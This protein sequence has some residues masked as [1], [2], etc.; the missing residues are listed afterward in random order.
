MN[1]L[2]ANLLFQRQV[3][4]VYIYILKN[5]VFVPSAS[6]ILKIFFDDLGLYNSRNLVHF[7]SNRHLLRA[8]SKTPGSQ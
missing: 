7:L 2:R 5:G 6:D 1:G 8:C 3:Q 4:Y